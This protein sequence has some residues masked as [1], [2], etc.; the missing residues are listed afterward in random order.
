MNANTS[1]YMAVVLFLGVLIIAV[2]FSF[3]AGKSEGYAEGFFVGNSSGFEEGNRT[4]FGAGFSAGN[5]AGYDQGY[6]EGSASGREEGFQ[7]GYAEG[8]S[9]GYAAGKDEGY[10]T[11]YVA[12]KEEGTQEG[13]SRGYSAGLN[14]SIPHKYSLRD[15]TYT[16]AVEFLEADKTDRNSYVEE[17]FEYVCIDYAIEVCEN[18]QKLHYDCHAV[19]LVFKEA[20]GA[21]VI[22]SFDTIDKGWVFFEPQDDRE[23]KAGVGVHYYRENRYVSDIA[24]DTIIKVNILP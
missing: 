24:D 21:H 16:E 5:E 17:N 15:P 9:T 19:E 1:M 2:Y 22:V 12:G 8:N 23:V 13:Y 6:A 7:T 10:S 11:G 3:T 14:D 18:A 20:E 4:G